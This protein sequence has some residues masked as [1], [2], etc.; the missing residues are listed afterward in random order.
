MAWIAV[1]Y[2]LNIS[3]W[4][5]TCTFIF[6]HVYSDE[7]KARKHKSNQTVHM[8]IFIF[9]ISPRSSKALW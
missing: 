6:F 5:G 2:K 1:Q 8:W 4:W 9:L 3:F 7:K